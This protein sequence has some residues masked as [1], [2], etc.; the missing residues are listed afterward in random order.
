MG[1]GDRFVSQVVC[2]IFFH[3]LVAALLEKQG[4]GEHIVFL[5]VVHR[6]AYWVEPRRRGDRTELFEKIKRRL[7]LHYR[8]CMCALRGVKPPVLIPVRLDGSSPI[9]A[10]HNP[11][12]IKIEGDI[13]DERL[14]PHR[15]QLCQRLLLRRQVPSTGDRRAL[16]ARRVCSQV[17][18]LR[19]QEDLRRPLPSLVQGARRLLEDSPHDWHVLPVPARRAS[20]LRGCRRPPSIALRCL[21]DGATFRAPPPHNPGCGLRGASAGLRAPLPRLWAPL[22]AG[23]RAF[24]RGPDL[25]R[26][27]PRFVTTA[28]HRSQPAG[29]RR[30]GTTIHS[31][32][33]TRTFH[34]FS[35]ANNARGARSNRA[36][37]RF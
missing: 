34:T 10:R 30:G 25:W 29:S 27:S 13:R 37:L 9:L 8:L 19:S 17:H 20:R 24:G 5:L 28:P 16:H 1:L 14:A 6:P 26:H 12:P 7:P 31:H 32:P 36:R 18:F 23:F 3:H 15:N 21:R 11:V 22:P 35:F 33:L 2:V 4:A